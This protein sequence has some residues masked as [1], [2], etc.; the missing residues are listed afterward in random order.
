MSGTDQQNQFGP[1]IEQ[2]A[3][4]MNPS[5]GYRHHAF[6]GILVGAGVVSN[7]MDPL[8]TKCLQERWGSRK[9]LFLLEQSQRWIPVQYV[10]ENATI[11]LWTEEHVQGHFSAKVWL[12]DGIRAG[13][14][15]A[16]NDGQG[17]SFSY[18]IKQ[19]L[20]VV[21][22]NKAELVSNGFQ[23]EMLGEGGV[24]VVQT[25]DQGIHPVAF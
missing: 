5:T 2:F 21:Y 7:G 14:E 25:S 24:G 22:Y 10:F 17:A 12:E 6:I 3:I 15:E 19:W 13:V 20:C 18:G 11:H 4:G 1:P 23:K 9:L 16:L 8:G